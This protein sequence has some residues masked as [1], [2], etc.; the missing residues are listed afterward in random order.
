MGKAIVL[1]DQDFSQKN[2][3]RVTFTVTDEERA[4]R[5]A[6]AYCT[7]IGDDTLF[8]SIYAFTLGLLQAG[9][10]DKMKAVYPM[11]GDTLA[12]LRTNLVTPG[13]NDLVVGGNA[14]AGTELIDFVRTIGTGDVGTPTSPLSGRYVFLAIGFICHDLGSTGTTNN[15]YAAKDSGSYGCYISVTG[16]NI[17]LNIG[18]NTTSYTFQWANPAMYKHNILCFA[19]DRNTGDYIVLMNGEQKASGTFPD[20]APNANIVYNNI[21]G[22]N[23]WNAKDTPAGETIETNTALADGETFFFALGEVEPTNA[24]AVSQAILNGIITDKGITPGA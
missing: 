24:E 5:V 21:L 14:S 6:S 18:R 10:W 11:Y 23:Y 12:K 15:W 8:D 1:S 2:L 9:L 20:S 17:T 22:Q 13:T 7:S 19:V 16:A 4:S 3:G